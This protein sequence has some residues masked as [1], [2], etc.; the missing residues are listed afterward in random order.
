MIYILAGL[1][2]LLGLYNLFF[3]SKLKIRVIIS[4][5]DLAVYGMVVGVF[6]IYHLIFRPNILN[7]LTIGL[8]IIFWSFSSNIGRGFDENF[9]YTN[10]MNPFVNKKLKISEIKAASFSRAGGKLLLTLDFKMA[11]VQDKQRFKLK[12]EKSLVKIL[13]N[14]KIN[15]IN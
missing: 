11:N 1:F 5:T 14:Q 2:T 13:K 7:T 8:A 3:V 15:L 4:K 9:V 10:K 6:I 12:D